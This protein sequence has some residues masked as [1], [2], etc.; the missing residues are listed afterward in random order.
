[1]GPPV[2]Q[3]QL[4]PTEHVHGG[5]KC[6]DGGE[7]PPEI[8]EKVPVDE[9]E[10]DVTGQCDDAAQALPLPGDEQADVDGE[11]TEGIGTPGRQ[12]FADQE[13]CKEENE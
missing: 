12:A 11:P 4:K 6:R 3:A 7:R 8:R 9:K 10:Q 1:M 5:H 2:L 13:G